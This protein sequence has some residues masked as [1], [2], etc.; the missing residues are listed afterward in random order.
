[1]VGVIV[2]AICALLFIKASMMQHKRSIAKSLKVRVV[3]FIQNSF[4]TVQL[5]LYVFTIVLIL[6]EWTTI[7]FITVR[8]NCYGGN[9]IPIQ[10]SR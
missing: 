5:H 10:C 2:F 8:L 6:T 1:V 7:N 3:V 4:R 9:S